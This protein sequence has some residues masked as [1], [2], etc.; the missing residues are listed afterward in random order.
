[1]GSVEIMSV[2]LVVILV[3]GVSIPIVTGLIRT[4]T[5]GGSSYTES[6]VGTANVVKALTFPI[7]SVVS[8]F[9]SGTSAVTNSTVVSGANTSVAVVLGPAQTFP[10]NFSVGVNA[11]LDAYDTILVIGD[12][13]TLGFFSGANFTNINYTCLTTPI[14]TVHYQTIK[15]KNISAYNDTVAE[16]GVGNTSVSVPVNNIYPLATTYNIDVTAEYKE[17]DNVSVS[18]EG[19]LLGGDGI[20]ISGVHTWLSRNISE[21]EE[22][23]DVIFTAS[24]LDE[25]QNSS[26]V[27]T[28]TGANGTMKV[29]VSA[30]YVAAK[31][32]NLSI[33]TEV[34]GGDNVTVQIGATTIGRAS[35]GSDT[36]TGLN[37]SLLASPMTVTFVNNGTGSNVTQVVAQYNVNTG[38][39]TNITNISISY[40]A[41]LPATS[42]ITKTVVTY[43]KYS[44]YTNYSVN[45]NGLITTGDSG[46]FLGTYLNSGINSPI[47]LLIISF[48]PVMLGILA[49]LGV[50]FYTKGGE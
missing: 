33:F 36:W 2:I 45:G 41:L 19:T 42:N 15:V 29:P 13:C 5:V 12:A 31:T 22:P 47:V 21:L 39:G 8:L 6:W 48:V 11:E 49:L 38:I 1:M 28:L 16:L 40:P 37:G 43:T 7:D 10:T 23:T 26:N 30:F 14:F 34:D 9:K 20:V 18:V 17:G 32:F 44:A 35:G 50:W 3:V 25:I 4:V 46:N 24:R 27:T